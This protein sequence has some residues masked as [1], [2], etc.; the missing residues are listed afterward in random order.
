M[1]FSEYRTEK[2]VSWNG[3]IAGL[4][5]W[6]FALSALLLAEALIYFNATAA[7]A[8]DIDIHQAEP[9]ITDVTTREDNYLLNCLYC[10]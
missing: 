6:V 8:G 3:V 7:K 9:A 4:G 5:I 10:E 1:F 2:P